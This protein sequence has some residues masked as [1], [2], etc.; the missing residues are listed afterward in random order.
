IEKSGTKEQPL[1]LEGVQGADGQMPVVSGND[2]FPSN[3]W[4]PVKDLPGV[5]RADLFTGRLG[6]A[7]V[8]GKTL[9]ERSVPHEL[10]EGEYCLNRASKEFVNLRFDGKMAPAEGARQFGKKWKRIRTDDE[11]FIDLVEALGGSGRNAVSW[12]STFVWV[13][14]KKKRKTE[15]HPDFPEPI[16][17]RVEVKGEFRAARMSGSSLGAQVNKYRI[18]CNGELLPSVIFS[19]ASDFQL[20]L[21]H[22]TRN[23]GFSDRWEYFRFQEGW[24]H[25]VF[26]WD[27]TTRPAKSKFRFGVPRGIDSYVASAIPPADRSKPGEGAQRPF[28]A[29]YL[30]LGP[31]ESEPDRGVYVRLPGGTN[32]NF[33]EID[34]AARGSDLISVT[35]DFV[36][37][38]GFEIRHGAQF[39]QRAQV[40]V[41]GEGI[42]LEGCLIRDSEVSAIGFKC[43]KDRSAAPLIL[44]NNWIANPGNVGITGVGTSD[45]LTAENQNTT[46][47]GRS[48]IIIE[49][50]TVT[51][52][53]WAGFPSFWASGGM[54]VFRL[55]GAI[56]RGNTV[57]GGS[58]PGIWLDWEHY[59]NRLEGNLF[60][61]GWA[62][63][64]G[65]EASPG[66]NLMANN[67]SID[68]RPGPV[69]FRH[70]LLSWSSD[71]N[72]AINN[73][74]DG[75]WNPLPA[76]QN[77]V[78]SGG[79]YLGEG[80]PDRKTR[81]VPLKD[82]R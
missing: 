13:P 80:G 65:I 6:T 67:L 11:G 66:P 48:S 27:T 38:R 76:W 40:A 35:G 22:P 17:G 33:E 77:K 59:G 31:F 19:S 28:I 82:R 5:Y 32:P 81:W 75:R 25:L 42:L 51:N 79:I 12:A 21:P 55:T 2:I 62:L 72:Y 20:E 1:R 47:P 61:N 24:N 58:G 57:I 16:T 68:L 7:S 34:L 14:P 45:K 36:E 60:L 73:T 37:V 53:N 74:L 41:E 3:A 10:K 50:N 30:V 39:Q 54:K 64:I 71:R 15:W 23:Y 52:N 29:E 69:W 78:G 46:T 8:N 4:K 56:I 9:T 26:Q 44:R 70:A 43:T 63:A 18:W 49:F